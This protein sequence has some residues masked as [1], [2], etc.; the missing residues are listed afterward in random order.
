MFGFSDTIV[1]HQQQPYCNFGEVFHDGPFDGETVT[2]Y[3]DDGLTAAAV[4]TA[5]YCS[6]SGGSDGGGSGCG[7]GGRN[8]G[9]VDAVRRKRR[10]LAAN[11]RER[12]RM[13]GLNEAFDRLR[14]VVQAADDGRKLSKFETLQMAQTYIMTLHDLLDKDGRAKPTTT[15]AE[16]VPAAPQR[17]YDDGRLASC[18]SDGH[19]NGDI[20]QWLDHGGALQWFDHDGAVGGGRF[21]VLR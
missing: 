13:N 12:R 10:R 19:G 1:T 16:I 21:A 17:T 7:G 3:F 2:K 8:G 11:A 20:R 6:T 15:N 5:E 18:G 14:G 4:S 9:Q